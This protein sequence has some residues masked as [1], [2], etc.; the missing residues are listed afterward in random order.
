MNFNV[1]TL[2]RTCIANEA[3]PIAKCYLPW[4]NR[5]KT[6]ILFGCSS[7]S[8]ATYKKI[9]G[10][11]FQKLLLSCIKTTLQFYLC[12][13]QQY[14]L[15]LSPAQYFFIFVIMIEKLLSK[16]RIFIAKH[17]NGSQRKLIFSIIFSWTI[18]YFFM[19]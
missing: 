3:P 8:I 6:V 17:D 2:S 16:E 13:W 19:H 10:L 7:E 4:D 18:G 12:Y 1:F 9:Q 14:H 5:I 11:N 15:L